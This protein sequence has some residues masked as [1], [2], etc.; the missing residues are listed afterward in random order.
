MARIASNSMGWLLL[1][2]QGALA[3]LTV[4]VENTDSIKAAAALVAEDLLGFYDGDK[5]G[6][7]PGILPEVEDGVLGWWSGGVLWDTLLDYK[8]LTGESKYDET[9][10]RGIRFQ[11]G[12][13]DDFLSPN[14]TISTA[15]A[16]Q[17]IWALSTITANETSLKLDEDSPKWL[18]LASNVFEQLNGK[19]RRV[20][21]GGCAGALR[22][23]IL[24]V[25]NGYDYVD[26]GSNIVFLNLAAQLAHL[27]GNQ[28][29]ADAATS[30]YDMLAR[31]GFVTKDF[32]VYDGAHVEECKDI[33]KAQFSWNAAYLLEGSAYMY[34]LTGDDAWK[35]RV[36]GLVDRTL[37]VFFPDGVATEVA[38][39]KK[40][41]C[42]S[43]MHF[44]KGILH[45]AFAS[46]VKF[47]PHTASKV[48]PSLKSSAKK[49]A[50][51][52]TGGENGRMCGFAWSAGKFDGETGPAQQMN[53]LSALVSIL[54][55][56]AQGSEGNNSAGT[57]N[58]NGSGNGNG[59]G[60]GNSQENTSG[61]DTQG[62][63]G[64]KVSVGLAFWGSLLLGSL[65]L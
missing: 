28:T 53:V 63:A 52:C 16:D 23:Q 44:F 27:T 57:G 50:A 12:P 33:N 3:G 37:E 36:D 62:N 7:I 59:N 58:G 5:P 10:S 54:P 38:C 41:I 22:W 17:G 48:L 8:S 30:T 49:A 1:A 45:R 6:K 47:A 13:N 55:P 60:N 26:S 35:T 20:E 24:P 4:D 29:Y 46:T 32:N 43:D 14:W 25:N 34:N 2:A 9:I 40:E 64:T 56:N 61:D 18:T 39:E 19:A 11:V 65:L 42:N 21:E 15:N 51:E 31:I